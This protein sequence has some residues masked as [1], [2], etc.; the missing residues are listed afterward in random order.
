M[1]RKSFC[2]RSALVYCVHSLLAQLPSICSLTSPSQPWTETPEASLIPSSS[3]ASKEG[4][5]FLILF[6]TFING[7]SKPNGE[8]NDA[9]C[10]FP[11]GGRYIP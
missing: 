9:V 5:G 2:Q 1:L 10:D 8:H 6:S 4:R 7:L 3:T 11:G